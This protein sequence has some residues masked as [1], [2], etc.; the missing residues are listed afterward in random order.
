MSFGDPS[1]PPSTQPK[2]EKAI[3][4]SYETFEAIFEAEHDDNRIKK[5]LSYA[6]TQLLAATTIRQGGFGQ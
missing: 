3:Q 1:A 6:W 4:E 5:N 2:L